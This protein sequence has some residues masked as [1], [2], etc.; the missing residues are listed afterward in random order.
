[1]DHIDIEIIDQPTL[2]GGFGGLSQLTD[3][4][5]L[6]IGIVAVVLLLLFYFSRASKAKKEA[7]KKAKKEEAQMAAVEQQIRLEQEAQL[8]MQQQIQAQQQVPDQ[9]EYSP[10]EQEIEQMMRDF[11]QQRENGAQVD[12]SPY[13]NDSMNCMNGVCYSK[14]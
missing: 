8:Q 3:N 10:D 1:M 11:E 7:A 6:L 13:L 5:F 4:K 12:P 9:A 14:V 2:F